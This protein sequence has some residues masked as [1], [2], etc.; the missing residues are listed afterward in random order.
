[1]ILI[2][3]TRLEVINNHINPFCNTWNGHNQQVHHN[4]ETNM[5]NLRNVSHLDGH[6]KE[7]CTTLILMVMAGW[8][9]QLSVIIAS[10]AEPLSTEAKGG[11]GENRMAVDVGMGSSVLLFV[12][13][14]QCPL[15]VTE[16]PFIFAH[17]RVT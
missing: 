7:R 3:R 2:Y 9:L 1:M 4:N 8:A 15:T 6:M 10:R 17:P 5:I 16:V 13:V 11:T 14:Q 12:F